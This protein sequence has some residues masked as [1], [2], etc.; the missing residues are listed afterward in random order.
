MFAGITAGIVGGIVIGLLSGSHV[1]VS[2]PAAGLVVIVLTA[3][4]RIGSFRGFLV[5]VALSGLFQ[6]IFGMLRFGAIADY[7]PNSVVKGL[8]AGIGL[9]IIL[10]QIPHALGRDTDFEGDFSFLQLGGNNTLTELA[11][12]VQSAS[13]GAIIIFTVGLALLIFWDTLARKSR[14]FQIVPGQLAVVTAA[15]GFNQLF[16]VVAPGLKLMP[17]DHLSICLC[18]E[19]C[20]F[21][22]AIHLAGFLRYLEQHGMD[23][24]LDHRGGGKP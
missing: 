19:H 22:L 4:Q 17:P 2:G 7:V 6:L 12:S 5:A 10:K 21:L 15:I 24:R 11:H 3:V 9:L 8:L 23:Q 16:G 18:R 20:R 13:L 1:S 14:L